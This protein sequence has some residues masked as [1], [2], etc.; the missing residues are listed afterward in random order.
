MLTVTWNVGF[1]IVFYVV[2]V[3]ELEVSD[4]DGRQTGPSRV[5]ILGLQI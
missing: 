4:T 2:V 5:S 3:H 1:E